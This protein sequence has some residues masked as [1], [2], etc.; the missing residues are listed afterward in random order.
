MVA[1]NSILKVTPRKAYPMLQMIMM[2]GLVANLLGSPGIGK[3]A[4]VGKLAEDANLKMNDVRLSTYTPADMT[5]LPNFRPDGTAYFSPFSSVFPIKG[6][7]LPEGKNGW[8]IFLDEFNSADED[9]QK[10]AYKL[11]LDRKVGE[12]DLHPDCHI[13]CAG[14]LETDR[15]LVT[16][17]STAMQSRL[18]HLEMESEFDE[19]V[20]DVAIPEKWDERIIAYLSRHKNQLMDFSPTHS[21]KTFGCPRTWGFVNK[22]LAVDPDKKAL[23]NKNLAMYGGTIGA[24]LATEFV[25]FTRVYDVLPSYAEIIAGEPEVPTDLNIKWATI[26]ML[27]RSIQVKDDAHVAK[28]CDY[29]ANFDLSMRVLFFRMLHQNHPTARRHPKVV[30][31]MIDVNRYIREE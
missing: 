17:S 13:I 21:D 9:V 30:T 26:T 4:V 3:S 29:V 12:F 22:L 7:P 27:A 15:A 25:G 11:V 6:M 1:I 24:G 2:A 10:A 8:L 18:V 5:G 23:N 19:W 14:N 16:H 31:A 28:I 20:E